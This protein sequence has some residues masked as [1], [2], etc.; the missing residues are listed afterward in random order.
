MLHS[1]IPFIDSMVIVTSHP[2]KEAKLIAGYNAHMGG[3][4][5]LDNLL[6]Y[7]STARIRKIF[8]KKALRHAW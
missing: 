7:F 8:F 2:R 1:W 4:D 3:V 5:L 6:S